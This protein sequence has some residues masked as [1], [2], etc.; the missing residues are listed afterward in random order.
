MTCLTYTLLVGLFLGLV[1]NTHC[2][3]AVRRV[4]LAELEEGPIAPALIQAGIRAHLERPEEDLQPLAGEEPDE[5]SFD[6][7]SRPL[8]SPSR[9]DT[10]RPRS[11]PRR[12]WNAV[13]RGLS[14][15]SSHRE[16]MAPAEGTSKEVAGGQKGEGH[17][18]G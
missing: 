11:G 10:Q 2:R 18:C 6:D 12:F 17:E 3:S 9:P 4:S 5:G 8:L 13:G 14:S 7:D 1:G 15:I 16:R